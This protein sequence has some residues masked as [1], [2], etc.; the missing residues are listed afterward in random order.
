MIFNGEKERQPVDDAFDY[1]IIGSGAAGAAA[2]RVLADTGASLAV[3]EEGP[4]VDTKEFGDTVFPAFHRMFR[5]MGGT[6]ARGRAFI[7]VVQ[8]SCLGGSTVINSAI[9]WRIPDDVWEPWDKV[10][11]LGEALPLAQLHRNWDLIERELN[12]KAIDRGVWGKHNLHMDTARQR[13]GISAHVIRRGDTG[14][15]GSARCLTGC[16]HGAKQSML[17]SYLPYA[18]ARGAV[19]YTSARVERVELRGERAV[20]VHGWF[21]VPPHKKR[22]APFILRARKGVLLAASAIQTPGILRKSGV[23]SPHVGRHFQAHPGTP[24]MG[25]WPEPVN[26]WFGATQGYDADEHRQSGR[27]KIETISLPPEIAFARMPGVG[28][29]WLE[30]MAE[31]Q[32]GAIW[33]VQ[34]RS[35]AEGFVGDD[36]FLGTNVHFDLTPQDMVNVRKG[37]RFTAEMMFAAG[38]REIVLGIHGLPERLTDPAQVKLL[39]E[40]P[41]NPNAYS[42]IMSHLFGTARMSLHP[43]DGVVGPN[44]AVHGTENFFVVDSSVFPTNLGVN[45]QHAIM[46]VA[47][48]AA[49]RIAGK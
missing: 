1:V 16:P 27:F 30:T 22:I 34:L 2:A 44:F 6:I 9:I 24:L 4:A 37:L 14:C 29:R 39:E 47:M 8:G 42:W 32:Y 12:V 46:G 25:L 15:R 5:N 49:Q 13:L 36:G 23:R 11:G 40:G 18:S 28:R 26:M 3:V 7:P 48:L 19:L 45:P 35:Y 10:F 38:A 20:A 21:H 33:A 43:K 17:V 31:T 41:D